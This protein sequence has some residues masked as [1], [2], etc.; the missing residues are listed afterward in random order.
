[1][2]GGWL[3]RYVGG[4][5][6]GGAQRASVGFPPRQ[7]HVGAGLYVLLDVKNGSALYHWRERR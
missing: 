6:D 2:N 5:R 7:I 3:L 4:P 1:V